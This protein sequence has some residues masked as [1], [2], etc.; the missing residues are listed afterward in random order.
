[1]RIR[2]RRRTL[3]EFLTAPGRRGR[4]ACL[5]A[6]DPLT[7]ALNFEDPGAA[8][9]I[10]EEEN[11]SRSF[12]ARFAVPCAVFSDLGEKSFPSTLSV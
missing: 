8:T 10:D 1:M 4:K 6:Y 3:A 11:S 9:W 5:P 7:Y 2:R 12:S